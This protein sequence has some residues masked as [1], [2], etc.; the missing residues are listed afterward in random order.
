[1]SVADRE[2]DEN[3]AYW[4][5]KPARRD[6]GIL[7]LLARLGSWSWC[8]PVRMTVAPSFRWARRRNWCFPRTSRWPP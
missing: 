8:V 2:A 7:V 3:M 1:M 6:R 5:G 4:A